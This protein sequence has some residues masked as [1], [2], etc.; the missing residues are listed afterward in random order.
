MMRSWTSYFI[1]STLGFQGIFLSV[2][3]SL[4]WTVEVY[5]HL[6]KRKNWKAFEYV[7]IFHHCVSLE[8]N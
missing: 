7:A 6:K 4:I 3:G 5:M 8:T 2:F 1:L